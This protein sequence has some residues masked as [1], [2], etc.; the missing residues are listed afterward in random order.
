MSITYR[1]THTPE[2]RGNVK[3][4]QTGGW[5]LLRETRVMFKLLPLFLL[6]LQ[7]AGVRSGK[8]GAGA[9]CLR[10]LRTSEAMKWQQDG[11]FE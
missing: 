9:A 7:M 8:L 4:V 3:A 5:T 1:G 6:P 2:M 11:R 10:L